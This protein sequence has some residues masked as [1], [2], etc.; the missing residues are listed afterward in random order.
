MRRIINIV[1]QQ[2]NPF[3]FLLSRLL[4]RSGLSHFLSIERDGYKLR[5][6]PTALSATLW[7]NP[8]ERRE[9]ETFI[10]KCLAPGECVID[11]GANIGSIA[12]AAASVVGPSGWVMAI[13]P[14][15]RQF[16]YLQRNV[17]YNNAIQITSIQCALGNST[18]AANLSDHK[19]DDQNAIGDG[20]IE[21]PVYRLDDIAPSAE[22]A[23][24]KVDV[25][26]YEYPV[27]SGA[28]KVL[29]RTHIVYFEYVPTLATRYGSEA[30]ESWRPVM[31]A[32]FQIFEREN[33]RLTPAVLPPATKTMLIGLKDIDYFVKRTGIPVFAGKQGNS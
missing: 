23:L 8:R 18:G 3:R 16:R 25:E 26:G 30:A 31:D 20:K 21:V 10:R 14:H 12:L 28:S 5:F 6:F 27:F 33:E 11:V 17:A 1:R 4:L 19:S 32:G 29:Q 24:L 22:I 15:P 7:V 2:P 13:E 9:E